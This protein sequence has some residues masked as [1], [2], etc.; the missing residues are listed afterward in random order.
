[1]THPRRFTRAF[2][3][4]E[5]LVV[6]AIIGLL[7][8][9]LLPAVQA[10]RES[11]RRTQCTNN[12]KQIGLGLLN[13][14]GARKNFPPGV[15]GTGGAAGVAAAEPEF[16]WAALT[17]PY[18][19]QEQVYEQFLPDAADPTRL[20]L[21]VTFAAVPNV[22][23]TL[24]TSFLCPSDAPSGNSAEN[25]NRP[26]IS[27][28]GINPF[29]ASKSNYPGNGGNN[30][31]QGLFLNPLGNKIASPTIK[32]FD[33]LDGTSNTIAAGERATFGRK[34]APCFASVW[35]GAS[36]EQPIVD[37]DAKSLLW[38]LGFYGMQNGDSTTGDVQPNRC[39]SSAHPGGANILL[40]DGSVRFLKDTI[41]FSP[42][43]PNPPGPYAGVYGRLCTRNYGAVIGSF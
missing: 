18:M 42:L 31:N 15:L 21:K 24:L 23:K 17:L 29:Y 39:I 26:F 30:G 4:V 19:E 43:T 3:L 20:S 11:A 33:I 27:V 12:M 2:T 14:E 35:I 34:N 41:S 32:V 5:L 38:S 6:I 8:G 10:A 7:I 28:P 1:M 22:A 16:G 37:W 36:K 13:Y 25:N 40:C 9:L